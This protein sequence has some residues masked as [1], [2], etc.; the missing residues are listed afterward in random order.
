MR[1]SWNELFL[2]IDPNLVTDLKLDDHAAAVKLL[3]L[4]YLVT[5]LKDA[6]KAFNTIYLQRVEEAAAKNLNAAGELINDCNLKYRELIKHIEANAIVNP[7]EAYDIL[8]KQLN[9]LIEKF[10]MLLAQRAGRV[11]RQQEEA[12]L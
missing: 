9:S 10:N 4:S 6:N 12:P 5:E 3:G 1:K 8:I 2:R 11:E 7:S